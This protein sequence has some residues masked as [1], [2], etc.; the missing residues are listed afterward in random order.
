[1]DIRR[2]SALGGSDG[3]L[4]S[5]KIAYRV[6]GIRQYAG[7]PK[8]EAEYYLTEPANYGVA[9]GRVFLEIDSAGSIPN[10]FRPLIVTDANLQTGNFHSFTDSD[11]LKERNESDT[12]LT[13]RTNHTGTQ[14]LSSIATTGTPD[15]TKFL[16]DDGVWA[17]G[18]GVTDHGALTGLS[19]DD[20]AQYHNDARGDARYAVTSHSHSFAS[21]TA[22]PTTL[23]GYSIS[24]AAALSHNHDASYSAIGHA[25]AGIYQPLATPLTNTTAA[26]TTAQETKLSGIATGATA[27]SS[28]ATLLARANHTGTQT[29]STVSDFSTSA[30]ARIAAA[31]V[32]ALADVIITTPSTGQVI[33]YNGS[34]WV[35]DTDATG[36]GGGNTLFAPGSFTVATGN[37]MILA[38]E[39][40]LTGSQRATL[41]GT[42]RMRVT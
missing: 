16:R 25:H 18:S 39:L 11:I 33:K 29:A 2:D 36:A 23:A 35:N 22:K 3:V 28:D 19:D 6:L 42:S 21:I 24:D 7:S 1:M 14:P 31:S 17:A 4:M 15:G 27:N 34:A 5:I 13:S 20:H 10:L 26:F 41:A 8:W 40:Q 30:D 12:F 38:R 9:G 37:F 32:N